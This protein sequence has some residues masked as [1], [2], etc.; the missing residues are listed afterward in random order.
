M[1][2]KVFIPSMRKVVGRRIFSAHVK[3]GGVSAAGFD[4]RLDGGQADSKVNIHP[5]YMKHARDIADAVLKAASGYKSGLLVV[6]A[7]GVYGTRSTYGII[8]VELS[9]DDYRYAVPLASA[10]RD[11]LIDQIRGKSSQLSEFHKPGEVSDSV[12]VVVPQ[13]MAIEE[14]A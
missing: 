13:R 6:L 10:L 1:S 7:P 9:V 12:D 11:A 8:T 2:G 4:V 3:Y 14:D 5:D